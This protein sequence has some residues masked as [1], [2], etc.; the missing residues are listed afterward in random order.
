MN[1]FVAVAS[2]LVLSASA[3][4]QTVYSPDASF[5]TNQGRGYAFHLGAYSTGRY[6]LMDGNLRNSVS[7]ITNIAYRPDNGRTYDQSSGTGRSFTNVTVH[8]SDCD[9]A[10]STTTLSTNATSTPALAFSGSVTWPTITGVANYTTWPIAFPCSAWVSSGTADVMADY[11]F[12]GGTLAN[13]HVWTMFSSRSYYMDGFYLASFA[14]ATT[15]WEGS[16]HQACLDSNTLNPIDI[17]STWMS[18]SHFGPSFSLSSY[19]NKFGFYMESERTAPNSTAI[20]LLDVAGSSA[21]TNFPGIACQTLHVAGSPVMLVMPVTTDAGGDSA[22]NLLGT[23]NGRSPASKAAVG[24]RLW[25]QTAWQ[26]SG[27]GALRLTQGAS[28]EIPALPPI[29]SFGEAKRMCYVKAYAAAIVDKGNFSY[30]N[31]ITKYN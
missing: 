23:S 25:G 7:I 1:R 3:F 31:P 28:V 6:Q 4:A 29:G 26:D 16:R 5:Q 10:S 9:I 8:L 14:H 18:M 20:H 2:V 30:F 13:K 11:Q 19:R 24:I 21:G 12:T 17:P 27:T 15:R 22:R